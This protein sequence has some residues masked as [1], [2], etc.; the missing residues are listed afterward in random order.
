MVVNIVNAGGVALISLGGTEFISLLV[1][2]SKSLNEA[3]EF[4]RLQ[5]LVDRS[6]VCVS[7]LH[8]VTTWWA[9]LGSSR[10][11]QLQPRSLARLVDDTERA[12]LSYVQT[13]TGCEGF[14]D[15]NE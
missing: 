3:I 13:L 15:W 12:H 6:N 14:R 4:F 1:A 11:E 2:I 8:E 5:A 9:G 10:V 7:Q